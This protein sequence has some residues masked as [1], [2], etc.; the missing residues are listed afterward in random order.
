MQAADELTQLGQRQYSLIVSLGNGPPGGFRHPGETLARE[1]QVH[2]QRDQPLLGAIVQVALNPAALGIGRGDDV[3]AAAGQRFH[4]LRQLIGA[5]RAQKP[6]RGGLVRRGHPP[7]QPGSR[8][9][10]RRCR[11]GGGQARGH[12]RLRAGRP[13]DG[14]DGS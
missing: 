4:P 9:E 10:Q 1:A 8:Q 14:D 5:A 13:G 2:G 6:P 7:R 11:H 12:R 3:G